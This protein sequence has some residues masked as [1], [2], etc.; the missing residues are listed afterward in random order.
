MADSSFLLHWTPLLLERPDGTRY[1]FHYY[2]QMRGGRPFYFSGYLNHPDGTQERVGRVR[3]KLQYD[4]RTRRPKKG[5][6]HFDML[7]GETRTVELEVV[8]ESG[9]YLG[10]AL[11]LG[12]D[13]K[14]HGM[15]RGERARRRR[16]HRRHDRAADASP[17]PSTAR[18][19]RARARGR[20]QGLRHLRIDRHGGLARARAERPGSFL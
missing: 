11:Y 16:A 5:T 8:G 19:D 12:F 15:W 17:H 7:S 2:L 4:D 10:T 13:G 1:E 9:F 20:R 14:K 18:L 6:I 3:P